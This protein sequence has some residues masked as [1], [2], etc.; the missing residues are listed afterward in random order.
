ME[1]PASD[2]IGSPSGVSTDYSHVTVDQPLGHKRSLSGSIMSKLSFLRASA[3]D[4]QMSASPRSPE[5]NTGDEKSPKK[6]SKAM[7]VAIQQQKTRRRK[8]SLRKAALLGR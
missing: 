8:G 7:A 4:N 1:S 3:D 5:F 6:T 2:G